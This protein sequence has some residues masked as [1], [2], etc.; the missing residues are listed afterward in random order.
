MKKGVTL[1][2]V[3]IAIVIMLILIASASVVGSNAIAT[4]NFEEYINQVSRVSDMVNEY[5]VTNG[6]LPTNFEAIVPSSLSQEFKSALADRND[7]SDVL[8]VVNVSLLND[9]SITKGRGD[10]NNQ[11]V[12][13]VASSSQNVYY[14][15]GYKYKSKVMYTK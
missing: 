13:L 5:Y 14:M 2:V 4:A 6:T 8:Y 7:L 3:V 11:D 9:S 1:S 12:F 10:I 15:K